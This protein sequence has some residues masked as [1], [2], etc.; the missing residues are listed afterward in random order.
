MYAQFMSL[1]GTQDLA[2]ELG[3]RNPLKT[4]PSRSEYCSACPGHLKGRMEQLLH[5]INDSIAVSCLF[6]RKIII[7]WY[8]M[9][10][11]HY[12]IYALCK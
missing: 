6:L 11:K 5:A 9:A 1:I 7:S 8:I 10:R 4:W 12:A 3:L 2:Q